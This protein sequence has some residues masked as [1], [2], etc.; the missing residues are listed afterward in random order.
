M[1]TNKIYWKGIEELEQDPEFLHEASQEF[2]SEMPVDEFLGNEKLSDTST[3][4]RD[5][6]KFL[7]FSVTA[8]TLAACETPVKKAIPY[9][10]KPDTITPGVPNYYASSYFD[11]HD[12]ASILVKTREGRPIKL[13]GNK[14][15]PVAGYTNA[16]IQGSILSLYDGK[17]AKGPMA[18]ESQITWTALD[19][20]VIKKLNSIAGSGKRTVILSS[21]IISPS[22]WAVINQFSQHFGNVDVV[23]YDPVSY[24]S[25]REANKITFGKEVIPTYHFNKARSIVS[26][27][28]DFLNDW[29]ASGF[30]EHDYAA[31]RNPENA[32][33]SRHF[34]FEAIMSLAGANAD[35]RTQ[36]K[37]SQIGA[38]IVELYNYIAGKKGG[39]SA[40]A[41]GLPAEIVSA[42]HVA[43][44]HLLANSGH[45]LVACGLNDVN[46]QVLTNRINELL[47]SYEH[48]IHLDMPVNLYR[49]NDKAVM[50]LVENI[51][52]GKVGGVILYN[53]NPAYTLPGSVDFNALISGL[54][55]SVSFADR[56][57]ETQVKYL[58]PDHHYLE[59]WNDFM[60]WQG[61]Y[62]LQQPTIRPLF[63]TR[64]A[65]ESLLVWAGQAS[66]SDKDS[67]VYRE[68]VK[69]YW[70]QNL[71][72]KQTKYVTFSEFWNYSLHDGV[73]ESTGTATVTEQ[74]HHDNPKGKE[75]DDRPAEILGLAATD[76]A[77][78]LVAASKAASGWEVVLYQKVGI[79]LGNHCNN[80][81]LQEFPDPITR[82]T[83]DN[84]I[85]M[86]PADMDSDQFGFNKLMGQKK[87]ANV[88]KVT[89]N[90]KEV[91][92]PVVALPGQTPGT[93][94][95][96][97]GYGRKFG[98]KEDQIIG[99][100]VFP[101]VQYA[102]NYFSTITAGATVEKTNEK[103]KVAGTQTHHTM[104]GRAIIKET[105]LKE[106]QKNPRSGN[107]PLMMHTNLQEI[108]APGEHEA[109]I[110]KVDYWKE[111]KM[112]NHRW[113]LS[114]DLNAC[115]GCGACVVS[116]HIENN[117]PVVGKDEVSRSRDM[118]WLR[119]DR[120]YTSDA[121]PSTRYDKGIYDLKKSTPMETPSLNPKVAFQPVMCQ[122]C[123]HAPCE[124][125]CPVVATTHSSEGLN[126]MTYNRCVGT[127]YCANNCPYKVRR[128]NWFAYSNNDKFD[129]YMN[130]D[131]GKLVLNPDVT[132][133]ARGVMEKC[134]MCVQRI[135]A[136]KLEAKKANRMVIDQEIQTACSDACPTNAIV[137]GD[138]NDEKAQLTE[139]SA[140]PRA[141]YLLEEVGV[142]PNVLYQTKIRNVE[143]E[144]GH[145]DEAHHGGHEGEHE[146]HGGAHHEEHHKEEHNHSNAH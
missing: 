20:D 124:T 134:S 4:R 22:T 3:N 90:G 1:S 40:G 60:P 43:G 110:S 74:A 89:V 128:F 132:V 70:Q 95:I 144:Y 66:R 77:A 127:R 112:I 18:G 71:Y 41:S 2:P 12:F 93:I 88:A 50:A 59:A 54:E 141:Y 69:N 86:S 145:Q 105:S 108:I 99:A 137:F 30:Y 38:A 106:F 68:F 146:N 23:E 83:W 17:R 142:K 62:T 32:H 61:Y 67:T 104:M 28:A 118:H 135:Q 34:Q 19:E 129:Y 107:P 5:F 85:T 27:G 9:L 37:P 35:Y 116:C 94:G 11:G 58:A 7:G 81:I 136:G 48:V 29:L 33:M 111:F 25:V 36:L 75:K 138:F 31:T 63:E 47:N 115:T 55:L 98:R 131:L 123:N 119:I 80:P 103:Y 117:V 82:I 120:Y 53:S 143:E 49:G 97:L 87:F 51:K 6:L 73:F 139:L 109:A 72:G 91:Q 64:A 39:A 8:A 45:A 114:I 130:D 16:R 76:A 84:Y 15:S 42:I 26:F 56:A 52:A 13:E 96:A 102:N 113:G 44:D 46:A 140:K 65:Q 100:N 122:H 121:D 126:Q 101:F 78:K 24:A 14:L 21:S 125:V 57:E 133:R 10:V 92:L 79:G